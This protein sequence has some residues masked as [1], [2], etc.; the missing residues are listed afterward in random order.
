MND[1]RDGDENPNEW[2]N[3]SPSAAEK[4]PAEA[5]RSRKHDERRQPQRHMIMSPKEIAQ[6]CRTSE[7]SRNSGCAQDGS[8]DKNRKE[9]GPA[10]IIADGHA[11]EAH[12]NRDNAEEREANSSSSNVQ[13]QKRQGGAAVLF[14]KGRVHELTVRITGAGR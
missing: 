13:N 4:E 5:C 8:Q 11:D 12:C 10:G 14:W 3:R 1:K 6:E 9:H 7:Q 2:R